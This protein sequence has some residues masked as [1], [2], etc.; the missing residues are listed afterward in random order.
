MEVL[1]LDVFDVKLGQVAFRR[2]K[3]G[4]EGRRTLKIIYDKALIASACE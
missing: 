4:T 3:V 2:Y 1:L